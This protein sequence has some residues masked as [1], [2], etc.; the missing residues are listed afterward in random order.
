MPEEIFV[1]GELCEILGP[2]TARVRSSTGTGSY[3]VDLDDR[4]GQGSCSCRGFEY[5]RDCRHL[6]AIKQ[7]A[8]GAAVVGEGRVQLLPFELATSR[9]HAYDLIERSA[10]VPVGITV[11]KPRWKLPYEIIYMNEAAPMGLAKV[12]DREEF[13]KRYIDRLEDTGAMFF[14]ERFS[15]ISGEHSGRGIAL[16]CYED[17]SKGD[18]CYRRDFAA[19][20]FGKIGDKVPELA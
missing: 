8:A 19:W 10:M 9:Y 11:M 3:A 15:A 16:L 14:R 2:T 18:Y 20:W 6:R 7:F 5:R 4:D 12:T 13:R 1:N 17:V